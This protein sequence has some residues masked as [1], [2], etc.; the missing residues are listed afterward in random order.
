MP[1]EENEAAERISVDA[2]E[3]EE[4]LRILEQYSPQSPYLDNIRGHQEWAEL[5]KVR[6]WA[7]EMEKCGHSILRIRINLDECGKPDD[8]PDVLA[9]MDGRLVGIEVTDLVEYPKKHAIWFAA[10]DRRATI[11][12]W[13]Q[14]QNGTFDF[15]WHG[16]EFDPDEKAKWER[17]VEANPDRYKDWVDWPLERFQMRMAEIVRTKDEKAGAKKARRMRKHGENAL[18]SRLHSSFLL[19]FTPELY[20]Q[21]HLDRYL[22]ETEVQRPQNF[23]RVFLMGDYVPGERPRRHPVSEVRP[24][25]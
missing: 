6:D 8:P 7:K 14:R 2:E 25:R 15:R 13:K 9:D 10:P 4:M 19:I 23:D 11:L 21:H 5:D 20:L 16:P 22:E 17:R 3:L 12:T 18:D 24:T 1:E